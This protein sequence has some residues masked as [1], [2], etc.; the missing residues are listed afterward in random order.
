VFGKHVLRVGGRL[1]DTFPADLKAWLRFR[2]EV[3]AGYP[4]AFLTGDADTP[5]HLLAPFV[6]HCPTCGTACLPTVGAVAR[7]LRT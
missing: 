4:A 2:A 1:P 7:P 6:A 3:F 5:A